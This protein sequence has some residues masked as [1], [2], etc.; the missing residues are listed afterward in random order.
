MAAPKDVMLSALSLEARTAEGQ[1]D[2]SPVL[3]F[4]SR[5]VSPEQQKV[6]DEQIRSFQDFYDARE[7]KF[8]R[9]KLQTAKSP[10]DFV[11]ILANHLGQSDSQEIRERHIKQIKGLLKELGSTPFETATRKYS[12]TNISP[13]DVKN[14]AELR[15][16][17]GSVL[18]CACS[19]LMPWAS[20][21]IVEALL[22]AGVD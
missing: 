3:Q 15:C 6:I 7:R 9:E 14:H 19:Q 5:L 10:S 13:N 12:A 4:G 8:L 2:Q 20:S 11:L 1:T 16:Q 21:V 18:V 17:Q 22:E